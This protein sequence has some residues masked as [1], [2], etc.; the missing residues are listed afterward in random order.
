MTK[1]SKVERKALE[2]WACFHEWPVVRFRCRWEKEPPEIQ[3]GYYRLAR[4]W[5]MMEA[6]LLESERERLGLLHWPKDEV[7]IEARKVLK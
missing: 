7:E 2:L 6:R 1:Q 5:L 4:K 3:R